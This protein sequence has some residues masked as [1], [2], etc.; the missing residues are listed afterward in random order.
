MDIMELLSGVQCCQ[1][2][3]AQNILAKAAVKK[4][5][6]NDMQS[7]F[8][9]TTKKKAIEFF[10][11]LKHKWQKDLL[12]AVKF[13]ESSKIHACPSINFLRKGMHCRQQR[14]LNTYTQSLNAEQSPCRS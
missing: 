4:A 3:V 9:A 12:S 13:L 1:L 2:H 6:A 14:L 5:M 8:N 11:K 10:S 7:I